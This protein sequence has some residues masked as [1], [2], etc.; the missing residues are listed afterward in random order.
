MEESFLSSNTSAL[1][2]HAEL[3]KKKLQVNIMELEFKFRGH[4]ARLGADNETMKTCGRHQ[5]EGTCPLIVTDT[6]PQLVDGQADPRICQAC[7]E[8]TIADY[9]CRQ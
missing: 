8:A 6:P 4:T 3:L 1:R 7:L 9:R 5:A 2:Q